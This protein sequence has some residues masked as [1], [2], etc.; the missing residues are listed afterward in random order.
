MSEDYVPMMLVN[1]PSDPLS[2]SPIFCESLVVKNPKGTLL[3]DGVSRSI[4]GA[5]ELSLPDTS[6]RL[7]L[8]PKQ[9]ALSVTIRGTSSSITL[10]KT[11]LVL[12][13]A[14]RFGA[15]EPLI[16]AIVG[17]LIAALITALFVTRGR[18]I[19]TWLKEDSQVPSN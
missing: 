3:I 14:G 16:T 8:S 11:Q 12:T 9:A 4:D 6:A 2:G 5:E 13:K 10:D 19:R 7:E 1:T 15:K 18:I 17:T